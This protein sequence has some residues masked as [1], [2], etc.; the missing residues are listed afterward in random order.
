MRVYIIVLILVFASCT[1]TIYVPN[2]TTETVVETLRDTI[3]EISPDSSL[4]VALLECDSAGNVLINRIKD[5]QSGKKLLPPQIDIK[6]NIL[7]ATAKVDSLSIYLTLKDRYRESVTSR[8]I[9]VNK[10]T[11]FQRTCVWGFW[12][13][14][15]LIGIYITF[16]IRR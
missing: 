6:D 5:L 3:V 10:L 4:L 1:R 13:L 15:I 16:K 9:T 12:V 2:T 11:N 8:T 14:V 7:T